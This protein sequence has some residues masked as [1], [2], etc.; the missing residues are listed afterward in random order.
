MLPSIKVQAEIQ[1]EAQDLAP[2]YNSGPA[3]RA[4]LEARGFSFRKKWGQNFLINPS[5]RAAIADKL[6]LSAGDAVWEI[7]AGLGA[8]SAELLRRGGIVT[9]FE[10]D[11]GFCSALKT[12]FARETADKTFRLIP[13]DALKTWEAAEAAPFLLGNL[14]YTI[15]APLLG[16]F[17]EGGRLFR[18][19]VVTV[20]KEVAWRMTARPG[21]KNYASI[22]ALCASAYKSR[23]FMNLKGPSFYPPPRVDSA[24]VRFEPLESR[25]APP[26][27]FYPL[28]RG[29]FAARRKT[30]A[31]NLEYFLSRSGIL[32]NGGKLRDAARAALESCRIAGNC[33]AET[34]EVSEIIGLAEALGNYFDWNTDDEWKSGDEYRHSGSHRRYRRTHRKSV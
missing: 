30:L 4:F 20:Q 11:A 33:R 15:A 27:V 22:S 9:A 12:I 17:I 2:E 23:I 13:G 26:P 5:A 8:M 28:V 3:L 21:D 34:L 25:R 14:P 29:L 1:D 6:E 7:G 16:N 31:N 18:R 19:I 24:S 32:K 10:V